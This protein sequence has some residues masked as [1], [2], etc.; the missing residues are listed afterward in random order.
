MAVLT[1]C[2]GLQ[3]SERRVTGL[4][5]MFRLGWLS[6]SAICVVLISW[7]RRVR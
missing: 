6:G 5:A 1:M 2:A 3:V 7:V 4:G